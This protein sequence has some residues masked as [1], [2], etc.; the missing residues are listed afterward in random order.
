MA[1]LRQEE[2]QK[3]KQSL[4]FTEKSKAAKRQAFMELEKMKLHVSADFNY[5][6]ELEE[7]KIC[8]YLKEAIDATANK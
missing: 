7:A 1:V 2:V 3:E 8:R 6:E 5:K 4:A